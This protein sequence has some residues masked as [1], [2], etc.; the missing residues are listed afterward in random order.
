MSA[1]RRAL[2]LL[3]L[4]GLLIGLAPLAHADSALRERLASLRETPKASVAGTALASAPLLDDLYRERDY[5]FAWSNR[6]RVDA[7]LALAEETR[8]H[9][10]RPEDFH[11]QPIRE[12]L[13]SRAPNDLSGAA[14]VDADL[15]LSDA[16]LRLI[17][18]LRH[19]KVDPQALDRKGHQ[20]EG[21]YS[22][23]LVRDLARALDARNLTAEVHALTPKPAFYTRLKDGLAQYRVMAAAGGWPQVPPGGKLEPGKRDSRIPA[24]RARLAATGEYRG[25]EPADP[26]LYDRTLENAVRVFQERHHLAVDGVIGPATLAAMNVT[27]EQRVAQIRVNLERMRW[28]HDNLPDD[29]LLVDIPGQQAQLL[30]DGEAV[31][32]SRVIVGRTDR[33]T[34]VFR[35]QVEY[36]EF[37]PTWTVPPTILRKDILPAARN[38]PAAV[39]AKGLTVLDRSG[40]AIAPEDVDWHVSAGSFPYTLRQPPGDRNALGQVKF[41]F[42]NRF[43]VYLHDTPDRRLF[44]RSQRLLSSGC[45]RVE[46][47]MELAE[48]LLGQPERWNQGSF[49][50]VIRS[51]KTRTVHLERPMPI[52][53]SYWTAEA[54]ANGQVRFRTDVYERDAQVL[55]ALDG[56]GP[57][58]LVYVDPRP[59]PEPE[60]SPAKPEPEVLS[61]VLRTGHQAPIRAP[62]GGPTRAF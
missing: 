15:V 5:R 46:R 3:C 42:P 9:G 40:R 39:R 27:A 29:Y 14:R 50:R 23:D 62:G 8:A 25:A 4:L 36:L 34:P 56:K 35:D 48:L 22:T 16:L 10:L 13:G 33:Q 19:G 32:S 45:V 37:N 18:H 51:G 44:G 26:R 30:R 54:D 11:S 20:A 57:I 24:V 28:V 49:E 12:L 55:A 1:H 6:G 38:D 60:V 59:Q 17:H 7:L 21:P 52:I 47:P 2:S 53:L 58:R 31:W 41:M 43:S 61:E